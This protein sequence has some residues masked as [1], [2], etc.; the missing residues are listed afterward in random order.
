MRILTATL[1]LTLAV[2]VGSVGKS[3]SA[4]IQKGWDAHKRGDYATALREWK[5]LAKQGNVDAQ[6]GLGCLFIG[7]QRHCV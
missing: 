3:M 1:C 7:K 5:P 4:D 6:N 2:L